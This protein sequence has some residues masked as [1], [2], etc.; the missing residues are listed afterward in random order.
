MP[1]LSALTTPN[2]AMHTAFVQVGLK[3]DHK[4]SSYVYMDE[5]RKRVAAELPELRTYLPVRRPGRFRAEPGHARARS[6]C[7]S[8]ATI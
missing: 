2:S 1:D 3:E 5:V 4:V 8:A 7:R 6:T